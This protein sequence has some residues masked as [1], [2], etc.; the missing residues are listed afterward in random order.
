MNIGRWLP[1]ALL[2]LASPAL[3]APPITSAATLERYLALHVDQSSPLDALPPGARARFLAGIRFGNGRAQP[4]LTEL[5]LLSREQG[6][7][8]LGLFGMEALADNPSL[9][10]AS[11]PVPMPATISPFEARYNR[12]LLGDARPAL[13][14]AF[15][16]LDDPAAIGRLSDYE[17]RLLLRL[18]RQT[19]FEQMR[20]DHVD[21][22]LQAAAELQRR[23][24]LP[25]SGRSLPFDTL[26]LARRF[27][28][29]RRY[30]QRHALPAAARFETQAAPPGGALVWRQ[31]AGPLAWKPAPIDLTPAQVLV[32]AGCHFSEEAATLIEQDPVLGPVFAGHATWLAAPPGIE[33]MAAVGDWNQRHPTQ[34]IL[35]IHDRDGWPLLPADWEMPT[36]LTVRDGRVIEQ[37]RGLPAGDDGQRERLLAMLRQAG[38]LPPVNEASPQPAP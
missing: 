1:L 17:L 21:A 7:R 31:Q 29:A 27:D 28:D 19:Q 26:L 34:P 12:Y 5:G 6:R 4:A 10:W 22:V 14:T 38:L 2:A 15:P 11:M 16:E 32:L 3:A 37:L 25:A 33:D 13:A 36:F 35:P 20:A 9:E 24:T 23:G 30:A 18:L 8:I